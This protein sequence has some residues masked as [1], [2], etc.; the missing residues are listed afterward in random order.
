MQ[1]MLWREKRKYSQSGNEHR[2][3]QSWR[4]PREETS[5]RGTLNK[6]WN[7]RAFNLS[8]KASTSSCISAKVAW[9]LK[10]T[11]LL[12]VAVNS[13][14]QRH[15]VQLHAQ[16]TRNQQ[17]QLK[18]CP[19]LSVV[20]FI[21]TSVKEEKLCSEILGTRVTT[22]KALGFEVT[23]QIDLAQT[24]SRVAEVGKDGVKFASHDGVGRGEAKN[25]NEYVMCCLVCFLC[26]ALEGFARKT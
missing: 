10:S 14:R 7:L 20:E 26:I 6:T 11:M 15:P 18:A 24:L 5:R 2:Y 19:V 21:R 1:G 9:M 17:P 23:K 22:L 12:G 16:P 13:I 3:R 25:L 8:S 4:Q